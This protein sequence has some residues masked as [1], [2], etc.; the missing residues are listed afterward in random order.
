MLNYKMN[1]FESDM[2]FG[3]EQ[4]DLIKPKLEEYF[5][6]PLEKTTALARFDYTGEGIYI[7]LKSRR[8]TK[9]KY[10]T[11]MIGV[12]KWLVGKDLKSKGNRIIYVFNFTDKLSFVEYE[13]Q[14]YKIKSGGRCDRGKREFNKYVFIPVDELI[15]I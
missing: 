10:P 1:K 6:C 4:E 11:T 5:K 12:G 3:L 15:D 2:K 14:E 13:N 8:N 7:E 9:L